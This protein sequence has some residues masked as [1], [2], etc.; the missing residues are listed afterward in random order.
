M[1]ILISAELTDELNDLLV[2]LKA[3]RNAQDEII[4]CL[5]EKVSYEPEYNQK[6]YVE[7]NFTHFKWIMRLAQ[8]GYFFYIIIKVRPDYVFSGS[9][10]FKHRI[11]TLLFKVK[12]VAYFR[13]LL[14]DYRNETGGLA[15][16]LRHGFAKKLFQGYLFNTF[17]ATYLLTTSEMNKDYLYGREIDCKKVYLTGPVWL[18]NKNIDLNRSGKRLIFLTQAFSWHG[19][20]LQHDSQIRYLTVLSL[21]AEKRG[22]P[23]QIRKHPRDSTDYLDFFQQ[24]NITISEENYENFLSQVGMFDIVVSPLS[25]MAF[26]LM[27]LGVKCCFYSTEELDLVYTSAYE[28][29]AITT[30]RTNFIEMNPEIEIFESYAFTK[31]IFADI[32]LELDFL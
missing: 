14:F 32:N 17:E 24:S 30:I 10:I 13:G 25:T 4:L 29:L 16:K 20:P 8:M 5:N 19:Y 9:S 18:E 2:I 3:N 11:S 22:I 21:Y 12:H 27:Y 23:L 28:K 1:K 6:V 26:E 15:D 7:K 31:K